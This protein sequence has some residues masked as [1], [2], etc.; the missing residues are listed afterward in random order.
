MAEDYL[1]IDEYKDVE[2]STEFLLEA[3]GRTKQNDTYWKQVL[4][5]TYLA[6]QGAA[7]CCLTRTDLT[8]PFEKRTEKDLRLFLN[9]QS[10]RAVNEANDTPCTM[11]D[12]E[13]PREKLASFDELL[14]RLP[15]PLQVNISNKTQKNASDFEWSFVFLRTLRN[16]FSHF[17]PKHLLIHQGDISKHC[18]ICLEHTL[19]IVNS[20][21]KFA[22]RSR[23]QST[24]VA[25]NLKDAIA[26]LSQVL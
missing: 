20:P 6:L 24:K 14:S 21:N 7:V 16:D 9:L 1:A 17:G 2:A 23:F 15:Q 25:Q 3:I 10:Q 5:F 22:N 8:G 18:M 13:Y 19:K 26:M 4:I 11:P 12:M